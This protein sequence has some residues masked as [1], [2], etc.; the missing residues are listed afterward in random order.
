MDW[1]ATPDELSDFLHHTTDTGPGPDGIRYSAW[2]NAPPS[3]RDAL[4]N[5]YNAILH[6]THQPPAQYNHAL[7]LLPPKGNHSDDTD[8]TYIRSPDKTRPISLSNTDN[9]STSALICIPLD[10]A[11][12]RTVS[13]Q[14]R[15]VKGRQLA[16]NIIDIEAKALQFAIT[17][18]I[19]AGIC[20]FDLRAAFPSISR[21]YIFW[22]LAM[23]NCPAHI[24]QA[25]KT[26][27]SNNHHTIF[28]NRLLEHT[29][30]FTSGVKQGC[31]LSMTLFALAL[32][33]IIRFMS[34]QL[35]PYDCIIRAYC[36]DIAISTANIIQ[37][38]RAMLRC[39]RIIALIGNLHLNS[40]KTQCFCLFPAGLT[41]LQRQIQ[42]N[43]PTLR[44]MQISDHI[45]YLGLYIG[46]GSDE[47]QWTTPTNNYHNAV[48]HIRAHQLGLT[49]SIPLYNMYALPRLS[50]KA[51]FVP[52]S[53]D[54]LRQQHICLQLLT[55]SP[56]H[57]FT[58]NTMFTLKQLGLP[59]QATSIESTSIAARTRNALQT[60]TTYHT[61]ISHIL[62]TLESDERQL[63]PTHHTWIHNSILMHMHNAV[64]FALTIYPR[65][66]LPSNTHPDIQHLQSKLTSTIT[67]HLH[68]HNTPHLLQR[69]WARLFPDEDIQLLTQ[70][71][72][73]NMHHIAKTF[74][75]NL[76]SSILRTW[77]YAWTT[78]SRFGQPQ[79]PCPICHEPNSDT[80]RHIHECSALNHAA[81]TALHQPHLPSTRHYLFFCSQYT[82]Q[83]GAPLCHSAHS[84]P[85]FTINAIHIY[86]STNTYHTMK[87]SPCNN[88]LH[89]YQSHI[90]RLLQ[91]E[92]RLILTY[93]YA[94]RHDLYLH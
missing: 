57:S 6:N 68:K 66:P 29:F 46:P 74:K 50:W 19:L 48:T 10:K 92:P 24:I 72:L 81:R 87:Y 58:N 83:D 63:L 88:V 54:T 32:D 52:P 94:L 90:K 16:D 47:I 36:D 67:T 40:N 35:S 44:D 93:Q 79:H 78:H 69:R 70:H 38:L 45:L 86:A 1:T 31:P 85:R 5:S 13:P 21:L 61:N 62:R 34:A 60:T 33:P 73:N 37:S 3:T 17:H 65:L 55:N 59:Q 2:R 82:T 30:T 71:A 89:T 27:Y 14:Q 49:A 20:A 25:I 28:L 12:Q 75:P 56:W 9:K 11:A 43:M 80:L 8:T 15:C 41:R 91:H 7:L 23:A 18:E 39:F 42:D 26:L 84:Y 51:S 53:A 77:M 64:Q 76:A 22:V 4:Y